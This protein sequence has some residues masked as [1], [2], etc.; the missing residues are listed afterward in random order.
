MTQENTNYDDL[1]KEL[2]IAKKK[3]A[4]LEK[5]NHLLSDIYEDI[6]DGVITLDKKGNVVVANSAIC[7]V[8][9]IPKEKLVGRNAAVLAKEFLSLKDVP[10]I[11]KNITNIL[12]GHKIERYELEY[13]NIVFEVTDF[14]K[15]DSEYI[16]VLFVDVTEQKKAEKQ[17]KKTKKQYKKLIDN[18]PLGMLIIKNG[19]IIYANTALGKTLGFNSNQDLIGL[20]ITDYLHPDYVDISKQRLAKLMQKENTV[21]ETLEEKMIK[22]DGSIINVLIVGHSIDY[23]GSLAIQGYIFDITNEKAIEKELKESHKRF[24]MLSSVTMEGILIHNGGIAIE[25]NQ[26]LIDMT[27]YSRE[28]LIN[29]NIVQLLAPKE[30]HKIIQEKMLQDYAKPYQIEFKNKNGELIPAEIESYN[31]DYKGDNI[32]VTAVRDISERKEKEQIIHKLGQ[33]IQAAGDIIFMTDKDGIITFINKQFTNIYGYTEDEIIGKIAPRILKSGVISD[34]LYKN[35]WNSITKGEI[36]SGNLINK[37]KNGKLVDIY[38]SANPIYNNKNEII[39]YL[40]IQRDISEKKKVEQELIESQEKFHSLIENMSDALFVSDTKGNIIECNSRACNSLQYSR[41]ELLTKNINELDPAFSLDNH[42]KTIWSK[43]EI[44]ESISINVLHKRKDGSTFPVEINITKLKLNGQNV[45]LGLARDI[46]SRM[47]A[48]RK[49]K[50]SEIKFSTLFNQA[51]E[52]IFLMDKD[53]FIDCNQKTL[54]IYGCTREQIIGKT[55]YDFSPEQQPDN[56]NSKDKTLEYINADLEGKPQIFEW[57]H[58]K[59]DG[60]PFNAEVSLSVIKLNSKLFVQAFIRDITEW[61]KAEEKLKESEENYRNIFQYS[62]IGLYRTTFKGAKILDCNSQLAEIFGYDSRE[63]FIDKFNIDELYFDKNNIENFRNAIINKGKLYTEV[64]YRKKDGTLFYARESARYNKEKDV[65]EGVIEDITDRKRNE[66]LLLL[67]HDMIIK[68]TT[69]RKLND[70][71]KI[72]FDTILDSSVMDSGGVYLLDNITGDLELVFSNSLSSDFIS[73]TSHYDKDSPNTKLVMQGKNIFSKYEDLNIP[74][75]D[76]ELKEGLKYIAIIPINS[77]DKVIGCMNF[78]SHTNDDISLIDKNFL[79]TVS[80]QIGNFIRRIQIEEE[81]K[82]L[83]KDLEKK[84]IDRT[85]K[86]NDAMVELKNENKRTKQILS[87]L[88]R[89]KDELTESLKKEK[90]LNKLKS[91]FTTMVSH[92]YRTP[93]TV[94]TTSAELIARYNLEYHSDK[95]DDYVNKI[96]LSVDRMVDLLEKILLLGKYDVDEE[97]DLRIKENININEIIQYKIEEAK[98]YDNN[99]HNFEFINDSVDC[100]IKSEYFYVEQIIDNLLSNAVKYSDTGTKIEIETQ[101]KED[102]ASIRITDQGIGISQEDIQHI[103]DHF[104]RAENVGHTYGSGLG[105]SIVK[106]FIETLKGEII[107]KS[108][109]GKGTTFTVR[110]PK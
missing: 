56:R 28:E 97:Y 101:N 20:S 46:T 7:K 92:Q 44:G 76:I 48:E 25:V 96:I 33:A 100:I 27:G 64:Q 79:V 109:P 105:L 98:N 62:P 73:Y 42:P 54:E 77:Q 6:G 84:V 35:F 68:L 86:L 45:I 39:G 43:F 108:E 85:V 72:F 63:E 70:I 30:Y 78:A 12:K 94:I 4:E 22:K 58:T 13:K 69:A 107:T 24:E 15:P 37:T 57:V 38:S 93:L 83:N 5:A 41:E 29:K 1:L 55:P 9:E 88:E 19:K 32:R 50:E 80:T 61:K 34:E 14:H 40:A 90:E 2:D 106:R 49:L 8:T 75:D 89:Y 87:D 102:Y 16:N 66:N 67:Q 51:P 95:I 47:E 103:F 110:L 74:I 17:L 21:V 91:A 59:Y 26:A 82:K 36:V 23:Q 99:K 10:K 104:F 3:I 65:I 60:T 53:I 11:L 71:Y 31:L 81:I 52:A 18:A